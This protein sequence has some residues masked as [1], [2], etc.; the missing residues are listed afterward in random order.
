MQ[1]ALEPTVNW[2]V[3]FA[4]RVFFVGSDGGEDAGGVSWRR[5]QTAETMGSAW[6][7]SVVNRRARGAARRLEAFYL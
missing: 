7:G 4:R 5:V 1:A 2:Q 6:L 3:I